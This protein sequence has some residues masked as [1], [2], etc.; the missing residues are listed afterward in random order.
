[1]DPPS[2]LIVDDHPVIRRGLRHLLESECRWKVA[3]E[4]AGGREAIE[5]ARELQ[6][7][8]VILDLSMAEDGQSAIR[9]IV[10]AARRTRVLIFSVFDAENLIEEAIQAGAVGY[11]L[12]SNASEDLIAAILAALSGGTFFGSPTSKAVWQRH[13]DEKRKEAEKLVETVLSAREK[14]ILRL[15]GNGDTNDEVASRLNLSVRTV[16]NHR[17]RMMRRLRVNS[18]ADLLH[19]AIRAGFVKP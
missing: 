2:I 17:A 10:L 8:V 12:K 7:D 3:G 16:E 1:M 14:E 15:L 4:A 18:F 11:V 6:P 5:K 19:L 13:I 9:P